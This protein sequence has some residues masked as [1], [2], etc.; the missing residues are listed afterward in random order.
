MTRQD[1]EETAYYKQSLNGIRKFVDEVLHGDVNKL[2][3]FDFEEMGNKEYIGE[4]NDPDMYRIVKAFYTVFWGHIYGVE[5]Y[6]NDNKWKSWNLGGDTL[7]SFQSVLGDRDGQ[8]FAHRAQ[9][10]GADKDFEL[11]ENIK[12]FRKSYHNLGNFILI[13]NRTNIAKK[14]INSIRGHF[15]DD[16]EDRIEPMRDY[17]DLFLIRIKQYQEKISNGNNNFTNLEQQLQKNPEYRPEFLR[18]EEWE[19]KFWLQPYYEN[20]NPKLLFNASEE[21]RLKKLNEYDSE[22]Y[23]K[24]IRDYLDRSMEVINYRTAEMIKYLKVK[25]EE[26]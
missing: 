19:N 23:L 1:Y 25:L 6:Y 12:R 15:R 26:K 4:E 7:N 16:N 21:E 9:N 5:Y 13:P 10:F 3:E 18:I 17:F 22:E 20:H 11:W 2:Q 8:D 14:G 24:L